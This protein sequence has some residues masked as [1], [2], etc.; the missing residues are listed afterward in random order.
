[1]RRGS[2]FLIALALFGGVAVQ[3][4]FR[5]PQFAVEVKYDG[6]IFS[7]HRWRPATYLLAI[8]YNSGLI[9]AWPA[10][11]AN[12]GEFADPAPHQATHPVPSEL[13]TL[14]E[15]ARKSQ[16]KGAS[17]ETPFGEV[18]DALRERAKAGGD[19]PFIE[20]SRIVRGGPSVFAGRAE[21]NSAVTLFEG[22][23]PVAQAQTGSDGEW[24]IVTEHAFASLDAAVGIRAGAH[25]PPPAVAA[26]SGSATRPAPVTKNASTAQNLIAKFETVVAEARIEAAAPDAAITAPVAARAEGEAASGSVIRQEA[27]P[28]ETVIPLPMQFV[29]NEAELT[30]DGRHA[31]SLLLEYLKLKKLP[32]ITLTGHADERGTPEY[33]LELSQRRL[34]A[35]E[36]DL[37]AGG[38]D[39]HVELLAK[40]ESEPFMGID[41][42]R[43]TS[44]EVMQLDRRVELRIA[45]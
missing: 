21:A 42:S 27:A 18:A 41:R 23:R 33:N 9:W 43:L 10:W 26:T 1:M 6:A 19:L 29:Y 13:Q 11:L 35:V 7:W 28:A 31:V 3:F 12:W 32:S 37:R 45:Q 17:S 5:P 2:Q 39:G 30:D 38:Y 8:K 22:D 34:E 4:Y 20:F 15:A 14:K 16:V 44:E 40:G 36:R 25:M 24:V